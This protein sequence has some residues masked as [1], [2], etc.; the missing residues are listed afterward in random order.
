MKTKDRK[1]IFGIITRCAVALLFIVSTAI[2]GIT[3]AQKKSEV[4]L[5]GNISFTATNIYATI[6]GN[7]NNSKTSTD[8]DTINFVAD[9]PE[10]FKAPASWSSMSLTFPSK[11]STITITINIK[12][13]SNNHPLWLTFND[14]MN[15]SKKNTEIVRTIGSTTCATFEGKEKIE[16]GETKIIKIALAIE[17][18]NLNANWNLQLGINLNYTEPAKSS[19]STT[20][21]NENS[22]LYA[23]MPVIV[24]KYNG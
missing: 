6:T 4:N 15:A 9:T 5:G 22:N 21:Q 13:N 19:Y 1:K 18:K 12:N 14:T 7:V 20:S 10:N 3:M 24:E 11:T 17:N 23:Q 16:A 8:L 2:F